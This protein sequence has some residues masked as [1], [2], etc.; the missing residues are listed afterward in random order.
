MIGDKSNK[1][2]IK[3]HTYSYVVDVIG[4]GNKSHFG[5]WSKDMSHIRCECKHNSIIKEDA[6][7]TINAEQVLPF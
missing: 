6:S 5:G 3:L 1:K 4:L 7:L 2:G